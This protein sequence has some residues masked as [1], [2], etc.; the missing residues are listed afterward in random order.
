MCA[1]VHA[2]V[3]VCVCACVCACVRACVRACVHATHTR[4]LN[5]LVNLDRSERTSA[6]ACIENVLSSGH[7]WPFMRASAQH[8]LCQVLM[9][10]RRFESDR[11]K[12]SLIS[13]CS[14]N[15]KFSSFAQSKSCK[16]RLPEGFFDFLDVSSAS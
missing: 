15:L 4:T 11:K 2:C 6:C 10:K 14:S 7:A 3:R 8:K 9:G 1:C 13:H 12:Q 16:L 5:R